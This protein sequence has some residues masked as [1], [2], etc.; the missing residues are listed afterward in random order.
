MAPHKSYIFPLIIISILFFVFGFITWLNGILIPYF[1]ICLELTNLQASLVM[2]AAYIAYFVMALPSAWILKYTGYKK[3][4]VLGLA[5][6]AFG[7]ILFIPAAYSRTYFIF[8]SGLFI[9]GTGLTLLQAAVNP[10]VAIVGPIESTAQRIGF[11]GLANKIA[12][13]FSIT[14]L[15]SVFLLNAD[16]VM[17]SITNIDIAKKAEIL[18]VYALKIVVPY[19]SITGVLILLA[20]MIYFSNF[21]EIDESQ[22]KD[23]GEVK[24]VDQRPTVF[25]YPWLVLGIVALF[26]SM[27]CEVIPIDG[28]II[29]SKSL[30]IPL[31]EARHFPTYALTAMLIGYLASIVLIPKYLSQNRALQL[32]SIWGILL[33]VGSFLGEGMISVYCLI[34]TGAGTA[35]LWGTIWG[36]SLRGLGKFTKVGGAM[37]LMGVVGGAIL[38][39]VF[40]RLIDLNAHLPQNAILMMIPP[41]LIVLAFSSWGYRLDRWSLLSLQKSMFPDLKK[42]LSDGGT[43]M[44]HGLSTM[45]YT[46]I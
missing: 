26:F 45:D 40:G 9:T 15:G 22:R 34:L 32:V 30:G 12:G 4:M 21:P 31:A 13:I 46:Q 38:P 8:L 29:Y 39:L 2:F 14:V 6:M 28:V 41:Y 17:A 11:M 37:L 44:D 18:D 35:V 43:A 23:E 36:L 3:G 33:S 19:L 25:H 20:A 5:V 1:K 7:T 16:G 10:Y 27:A 42:A 24:E